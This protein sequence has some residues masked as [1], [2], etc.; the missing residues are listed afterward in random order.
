MASSRGWPITVFG[1]L[2][3]RALVAKTSTDSD[4]TI[5]LSSAHIWLATAVLFVVALHVVGALTHLLVLRDRTVQR[6]L[7]DVLVPADQR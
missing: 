5:A 6:I 4:L 2:R 3:L 7:P 1:G